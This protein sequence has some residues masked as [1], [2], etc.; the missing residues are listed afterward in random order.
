M[1]EKCFTAIVLTVKTKNM[2][3]HIVQTE[4]RHMDVLTSRLR[5]KLV[6]RRPVP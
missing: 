2:F 6:D 1:Q 5:K 3:P 4:A